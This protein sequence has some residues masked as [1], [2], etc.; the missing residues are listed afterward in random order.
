MKSAVVI[1]NLIRMF[2]TGATSTLPPLFSPYLGY[3]VVVAAPWNLLSFVAVIQVCNFLL[4]EL[5]CGGDGGG[6]KEFIRM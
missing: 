2:A 6:L 4:D 3:L 1:R 5:V